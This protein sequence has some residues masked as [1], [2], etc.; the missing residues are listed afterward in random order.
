MKK[1]MTLACAVFAVILMAA[2]GGGNSPKA[3]AEKSLN[4]IMDKDFKGYA[5]LIYIDEDR[6]SAEEQEK[7]RKEMA[8]LIETKIPMA[9]EINGE[10]KGFKTTSEVIAED[11]NTA[12]VECTTTYDKNGKKKEETEKINLRKNKAGKWMIAM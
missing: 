8:E 11:G 12:T 10:L 2:C 7:Q 9:V 3:V 6:Y 5:A 4:C 1:I